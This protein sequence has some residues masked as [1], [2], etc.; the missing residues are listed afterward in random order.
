MATQLFPMLSCT[1]LA[2][3]LAF[4]ADLLD[5]VET[6]PFPEN[7]DPAFIVLRI[8]ETAA[9]ARGSGVEIVAEPAEMP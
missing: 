8:G 9:R 6:Y 5:G 2:G 7:G 1:D 3:S 4:Y